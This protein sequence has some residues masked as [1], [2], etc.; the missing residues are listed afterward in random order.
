MCILGVGHFSYGDGHPPIFIG[1]TIPD[2]GMMRLQCDAIIKRGKENPPQK[3][4]K[5]PPKNEAH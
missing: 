2:D 5:H 1:D 4:G 3:T